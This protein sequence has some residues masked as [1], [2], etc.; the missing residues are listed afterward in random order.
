MAG[1]NEAQAFFFPLERAM[2]KHSSALIPPRLGEIVKSD[3]VQSVEDVYTSRNASTAFHNSTEHSSNLGQYIKVCDLEQ[4]K[5]VTHDSHRSL[6]N[7][8]PNNNQARPTTELYDCQKLRA[9][10]EFADPAGRALV[11]AQ[12]GSIERLRAATEKNPH[13]L[14]AQDMHG[15]TPLILAVKCGHLE[16]LRFLALHD[17]VHAGMINHTQQNV[18]HFLGNYELDD[19]RAFLI[20]LIQKGA[21]IFQETVIQHCFKDLS[22]ME[23]QAPC[24][25][26]MNAIIRNNIPFVEALLEAWHDSQV[27]PCRICAESEVYREMLAMST[28]LYR[29]PAIQVLRGHVQKYNRD[30]VTNLSAIQVYIQ[31]DWLS[32][33]Q[34]AFRTNMLRRT[35]LP[36][37]CFRALHHGAEFFTALH[38]TLKMFLENEAGAEKTLNLMLAEAAANNCIDTIDFLLVEASKRGLS[39]LT[40]H[41]KTNREIDRNPLVSSIRSGFREVFSQLLHSSS[42]LLLL[43]PI[44]VDGSLVANRAQRSNKTYAFQSDAQ[45]VFH[46]KF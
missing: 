36:E 2:N 34:I 18:L 4:Y 27:G 44:E 32:L 3:H 10:T 19:I 46:L 37:S 29:Y 16:I 14:N 38:N 22:S 30:R 33:P 23:L 8:P 21:D 40:Q 28:C 26:L 25:P 41:F 35:C 39:L 45:R 42:D 13:I 5:K 11:A 31:G 17:H 20:P 9:D 1:N 6:S 43:Y 15:N 24:D 12:N 7:V